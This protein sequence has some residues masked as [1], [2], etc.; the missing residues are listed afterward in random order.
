MLNLSMI[1]M[2]VVY[3]DVTDILRSVSIQK[4]HILYGVFV[5]CIL[6]SDIVSN[7]YKILLRP[8]WKER[9]N[10]NNP[11]IFQSIHD[12]TCYMYK[13]GT[14]AIYSTAIISIAREDNETVSLNSV[15]DIV[16]EPVSSQ[17]WDMLFFPE[18]VT[19]SN[20]T[21]IND[22]GPHSVRYCSNISVNVDWCSNEIALYK[23]S[24]DVWYKT[25]YYHQFSIE[26]L[27]HR[28]AWL[29]NCHLSVKQ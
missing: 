18:Q 21:W 9:R 4:L 2:N 7:K 22:R 26:Y 15:I 14:N 1:K 11:C 5:I 13:R 8:I 28:T 19:L 3:L 23:S 25:H 17:T 20:T 27:N 12:T 6:L 29:K 10:T 16:L 24:V